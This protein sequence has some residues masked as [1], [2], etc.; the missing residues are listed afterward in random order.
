MAAG[1]GSSPRSL[2]QYQPLEKLGQGGMGTVYKARHEKLERIVALKVLQRHRMV[3]RQA[4]ARFE[5]E[6]KAVGSLEHPNIVRATDAGEIDEVPYL[7]MEYVDGWD[8]A[9]L[10]RRLGPLPVA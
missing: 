9:V 3:D 7:V 5:R 6:M 10:L 1:H 8:L 4:I 2:G